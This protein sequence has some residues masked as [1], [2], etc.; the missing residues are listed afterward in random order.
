MRKAKELIQ[1]SRLTD[2]VPRRGGKEQIITAYLN[3]IFYGHGAYGIAA[4]AEIYFG[5]KRPRQADARP[6]GAPRRACRSR[7]RRSIPTATPSPTRR[8]GWSSRSDAPP[9]VRRD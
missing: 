9:V 3:E 2:G 6:G 7:P 1:S 4:A 8:A 5:V